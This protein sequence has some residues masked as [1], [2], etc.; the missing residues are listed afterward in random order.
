MRVVPANEEV[1]LVRETLL[2]EWHEDPPRSFTLQRA[3]ESL[4]HGEAAVLL[5]SAESLGNIVPSTPAPERLGGELLALIRDEV[6]RRF[7]SSADGTVEHA[8]H[9]LRTGLLLVD[10]PA[11]DAA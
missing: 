4:D 3:D 7:A 6:P 10:L 5:D 1:D 9:G 8:S 2:I 11:D